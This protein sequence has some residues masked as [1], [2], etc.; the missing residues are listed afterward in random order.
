MVANTA[1]MPLAA[2]EAS[3]YTGISIA[4]YLRDMGYVIIIMF[5]FIFGCYC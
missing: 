4:E 1:D 2:R 3:I 5:V